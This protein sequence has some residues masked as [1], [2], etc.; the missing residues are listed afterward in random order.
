MKVV[1]ATVAGLVGISGLT[2]DAQATVPT[3]PVFYDILLNGQTAYGTFQRSARL[4]VYPPFDRTGVS[5]NGVN[6][7]DIG[8]FSGNPGGAPEMGAIWFA[9][10]NRLYDAVG[11][12]TTTGKAMVD[13]AAVTANPQTSTLSV[14]LDQ[15]LTP[16]VQLNSMNS[17]GGLTAGVYQIVD[18]TVQL[19]FGPNG[20]LIAAVID[21]VGNGYIEPGLTPYRAVFG[22]IRAVRG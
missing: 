17:R 9:T 3:E 11:F 1:G 18:G 21:L 8:L 4:H 22:N 14:D 10:N 19:Q 20:Q 6:A 7:R 12:R 16:T 2:R 13:I 15:R 5:G